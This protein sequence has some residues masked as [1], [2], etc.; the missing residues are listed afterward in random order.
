MDDTE[1]LS[2]PVGS[3]DPERRNH[4]A[5]TLGA[6]STATHCFGCD[7]PGSYSVLWRIVSQYS[8]YTTARLPINTAPSNWLL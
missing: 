1:Q 3:G 4:L 2:S 7:S 6:F 5:G 8:S